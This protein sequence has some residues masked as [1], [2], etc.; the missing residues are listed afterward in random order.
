[1]KDALKALMKDVAKS[2]WM[3]AQA[4]LGVAAKGPGRGL[5]RL[6]TGKDPKPPSSAPRPRR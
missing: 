4:V 1:M 6:F 5:Q 2:F 3:P